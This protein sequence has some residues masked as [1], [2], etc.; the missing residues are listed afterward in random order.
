M[1]PPRDANSYAIA[2]VPFADYCVLSMLVRM[3]ATIL[4]PRYLLPIAPDTSVREDVGVAV[5]DGRIVAVE[6]FEE[7]GSSFP[8]AETIELES[9][10]LMPGLVNAHGHLAMS[11]MRGLAGSQPLD[12]WLNEIVWPLEKRIV[13]RDFVADGT[14]LALAEMIAS[15]TTCASDHYWYPEVVADTAV[16]AGFRLQLAVPVVDS[17]SAGLRDVDECIHRGVELHDRYR[18]EELIKVAFGPHS[19]Y[20]VNLEALKQ[21]QTLADEIGADIH[22][23]LHETEAEVAG[24]RSRHGISWIRVLSEM[25]MITPSLQAVHMTQLDDGEIDC[26]ARGGVRVI[27]CPHSNLL[28]ASGRCRVGDLKTAG[29]IV[30]LGTDGAASNNSLDMFQ[31]MR[32]AMLAR[33]SAASDPAVAPAA[34]MLKMATLDGARAL[35]LGDEIGSIEQGK[36]AD[37]I[38]VDFRHPA[39]QPVNDVREHLVHTQAGHHVSH[40]WVRGQCLYERGRFNTLDIERVLARAQEWPARMRA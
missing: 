16:R 11:L 6:P 3:S 5:E 32:T 8:G 26:I 20:A 13:D 37:L 19:C 38:A 30:G 15:G 35:G 12:A 14:G 4:R 21:V 18:D 28:L 34:E 1:P 39:L 29:V 36:S 40:V 7:L 17:P 10:V 24:A 33:K 27:H 25:G 31:E 9:H 22:M 2:S 23:H